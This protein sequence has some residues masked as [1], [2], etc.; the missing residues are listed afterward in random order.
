MSASKFL[1][2]TV[3]VY[4]NDDEVPPTVIGREV[5]DGFDCSGSERFHG[6]CTQNKTSRPQRE[7][8]KIA[9]VLCQEFYCY[10]C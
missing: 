3:A 4:F 7:F 1:S 2:D 10:D 9:G 6:E 8:D 5:T